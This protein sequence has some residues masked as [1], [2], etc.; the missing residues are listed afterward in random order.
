MTLR[1]ELLSLADP[2]YREFTASLV[3]G[4]GELLGVR[5]PQ[6]R[7][8]ARRIARSDWR[9]LL[10]S[11]EVRYFEERLIE[12][13]VIGYAACPIGERLERVARFVS[14]IDNWALC[15]CFC[16]R[17]RA[18]EREAMWRFI[19]PY[20]HSEAEYDLRFAVVMALDNF[21]D[22][23]H[24]DALLGLL[25]A[26]R[27]EGYYARMGVAWAV[28]V[29]FVKQPAKTRP[30]LENDCPLDDWTFNRSLQKIR[31]SYRVSSADKA[32]LQQLKRP[33]K[34]ASGNFGIA[35]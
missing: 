32:A 26:I 6:L 1:E 22:E 24:I 13:L 11:F 16:W 29:C 33:A 35:K 18:G 27:H 8:I 12:G 2:R 17:L 15:D 23:E 5:I 10:D 34:R 30:W 3:P 7:R 21:V 25:G 28:S 19:E 9:T 31:E 4:I 14:R 20:F